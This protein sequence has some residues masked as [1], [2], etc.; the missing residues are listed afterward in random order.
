MLVTLGTDINGAN[1][2]LSSDELV[3]L[4]TAGATVPGIRLCNDPLF[5]ADEPDLTDISS[6]IKS[7]VGTVV[8][9]E[10][11]QLNIACDIMP[12]SIEIGEY[13]AL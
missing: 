3:F 13:Y 12:T 8:P 2:S 7:S 5:P 9:M 10:S 4:D 6:A 1:D 11:F